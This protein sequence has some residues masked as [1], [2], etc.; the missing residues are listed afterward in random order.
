MS[1]IRPMPE[2]DKKRAKTLAMSKKRK[3]KILL[4]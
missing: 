4:T 3:I 2:K 1:K